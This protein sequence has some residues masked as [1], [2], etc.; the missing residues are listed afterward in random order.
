VI[1]RS[2]RDYNDTKD[3]NSST[4]MI[5]DLW[6]DAFKTLFSFSSIEKRDNNNDCN[7]L[8]ELYI[9]PPWMYLC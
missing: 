4:C 6:I 5:E 8:V 2:N 1:R 9:L 3:I 7:Y